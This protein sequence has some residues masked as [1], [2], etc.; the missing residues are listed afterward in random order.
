MQVIDLE[1][2]KTA[3][4]FAP[5]D[6]ERVPLYSVCGHHWHGLSII[7]YALL[8]E[9]CAPAYVHGMPACASFHT[10]QA[11]YFDPL[12]H[13]VQ[14]VVDTLFPASSGPGFTVRTISPNMTRYGRAE[15]CFTTLFF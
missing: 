14:S 5:H 7:D 15:V 2:Y 8:A 1:L 12:D 3:G 4:A 13:D 6:T 11:A 10:L 9:V